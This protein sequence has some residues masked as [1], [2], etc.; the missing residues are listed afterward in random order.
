[1]GWAAVCRQWRAACAPWAGR[2][3]LLRVGTR[4]RHRVDR[5]AAPSRPPLGLGV[6]LPPVRGGGCARAGPVPVPAVLSRRSGAHRQFPAGGIL[7]MGWAAVCRQWRAACAPWAGRCP[8]LRVGTRCRHRVGRLAA[9]RG[10]RWGWAWCRR[11]SEG[12]VARRRGRSPCRRCPSRRSGAHRQFPAGGI[13]PMA[14]LR[15][16]G[17]GAAACAPSAGRC[18]FLQGPG[19]PESP[20]AR[21][22]RRRV[23]V[24]LP[25]AGDASVASS[26]AVAGRRAVA[27]RPG[28]G[29]QRAARVPPGGVPPPLRGTRYRS[30]TAMGIP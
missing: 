27:D 1:M 14:G 28:G 15:S 24:A 21:H 11:R 23:G 22:G 12:E 8:L 9:R 13:S 6:A 7:P 2:W 4:C 10:R 17:S 19:G 30:R 3:P 5:L 18:P 20:P 25:S 16:A 26:S 29:P